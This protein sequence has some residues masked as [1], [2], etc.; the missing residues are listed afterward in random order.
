M[1][2]QQISPRFLVAPQLLLFHGPIFVHYSNPDKP[3]DISSIHSTQ[4]TSAVL[5]FFNET[6]FV[7]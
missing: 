5:R 4:H 1:V 3:Y 6:N 2:R 7:I